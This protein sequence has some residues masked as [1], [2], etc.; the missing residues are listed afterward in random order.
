MAAGLSGVVTILLASC[1]IGPAVSRPG[2]V[3]DVP[4]ST[5]V[6]G[7]AGRSGGPASAT[8]AATP[9]TGGSL[10]AILDGP[11]APSPIATIGAGTAAP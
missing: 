2:F 4:G 8:T 3:F 10:A 6:Q 9:S 11:I 5:P 1:A 7:A